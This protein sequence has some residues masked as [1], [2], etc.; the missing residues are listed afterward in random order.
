MNEVNIRNQYITKG[1]K[2]IQSELKDAWDSRISELYTFN[3]GT[4]ID[5]LWLLDNIDDIEVI[6]NNIRCQKKYSNNEIV[7]NIILF[8]RNAD[9]FIEALKLEKS[10]D[11][12]YDLDSNLIIED[13]NRKKILGFNNIDE[14]DQTSI[15]Q[16]ILDNY[17]KENIIKVL[18]DRDNY[19]RGVIDCNTLVF[20]KI[21]DSE[22]IFLYVITNDYVLKYYG[23]LDNNILKLKDMNN[24]IYVSYPFNKLEMDTNVVFDINHKVNN[25]IAKFSYDLVGQLIEDS[26]AIINLMSNKIVK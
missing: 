15:Y 18:I 23:T 17:G 7:A 6:R 10:D 19:I 20:G 5:F 12:F 9:I 21:I 22:H 3:V 25:L 2:Y 11:D 1:R 13:I 4:I 14:Y 26:E 24:N 16:L 8:S